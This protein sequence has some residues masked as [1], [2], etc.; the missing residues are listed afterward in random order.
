M[1]NKKAS[2]TEDQRVERLVQKKSYHVTYAL[3]GHVAHAFCSCSLMKACPH[4]VLHSSN[5][6]ESYFVDQGED[7]G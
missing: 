2:E 7:M 3:C 6:F 5:E 4:N 1:R